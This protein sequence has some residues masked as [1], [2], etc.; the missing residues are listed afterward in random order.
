[1]V[2]NASNFNR[3]H[4]VASRNASKE[5]PE[6]FLEV[7]MNNRPPFFG[8]EDAVII[9]TNVAHSN[10]QHFFRMFC[11]EEM[12]SDKSPEEQQISVPEGQS[13]PTLLSRPFGT[14]PPRYSHPRLKPWATV[15]C[16][17]GTSGKTP[18][19]SGTPIVNCP[20]GTPGT[21]PISSGAPGTTAI[22]SG[23]PAPNLRPRRPVLIHLP[24]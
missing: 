8:T 3:F 18:I 23:A 5:R 10:I 17:S 20:Y 6:S 13:R 21:T 15:N 22:P 4:L 12:C 16:P 19:A 14:R 1:M 2:G 11:N 24:G 7:C 9:R